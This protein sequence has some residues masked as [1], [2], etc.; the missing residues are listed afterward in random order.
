MAD[1]YYDKEG[2]LCLPEI[3]CSCGCRHEEPKVDVYIGTGLIPKLPGAVQKRIKGKKCVL[4]AD[5]NTYPIAG[6]DAEEELKNSGFTVI[7]CVVERE[8]DMEPDETAVGEVLLSLTL[9]TDFLISCGSGS[10]TDITR[11]VAANTRKPFVAFGTAPSM[12]GYTSTVAPLL[13]RGLK[14]N[15][16]AVCPDII[17]CDIDIMRKAPLDMYLSGVGDVLGKYIAKADWVIGNI[18][19]DEICCPA[20][21]K[22]A[23]DAADKLLDNIDE[24]VKKTEKGT[25]LLTEALILAGMTIMVIGNTRAVAS[26]EHSFVHYWDMQ[27]IAGKKKPARH[28]TAVGVA[29]LMVWPWFERFAQLDPSAFDEE[30]AV[31]ANPTRDERIAFMYDHYGKASADVI[32][33][34]N[35]GDFL[36]EAEVRRRVKR[37]KARFGEI[38]EEIS[39][40]PDKRR[41]E[42]AITKL[43]GPLLPEEIGIDKDL[44]KRSFECAKD[45]RTRYTL[46][47]SIFELGLKPWDLIKV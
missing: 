38:Q 43:G 6:K 13:F 29:T 1:I 20:C 18:V 19:N 36:D 35:E 3:D 23:I 37:I 25:R 26:V 8:G 16:P 31:S 27:L 32:M 44:L 30:K 11:I 28:G 5:K 14:I 45:Y 40:L 41:I 22:L 7:R 21:C 47:K 10:V 24:I 46:M 34:E 4:V 39:R 33:S 12:D 2:R 42:E 17:M 9:D 15:A